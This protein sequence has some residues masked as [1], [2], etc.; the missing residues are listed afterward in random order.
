M[1]SSFRGP[2]TSGGRLTPVSWWGIGKLRDSAGAEYGLYIYFYPYLRATT[3]LLG[4][5]ALP[6]TGLRGRASV[7]TKAGEVYRIRLSGDIYR[8]WLNSDG[9]EVGFSLMEPRGPKL[10]RAFDLYG[11]W[12]GPELVLDDQYTSPVPEKYAYVT[13]AW[14]S[15]SAF[16]SP[17]RS[18]RTISTARSDAAR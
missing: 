17:C 9:M 8:A 2:S 6:A 10:R 5:K 1:H 18:L 13:L 15:Y 7:C 16:E 4:H 11:V 3:R 12:H 14:G